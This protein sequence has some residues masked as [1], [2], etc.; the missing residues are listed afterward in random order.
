MTF[1]SDQSTCLVFGQTSTFKPYS[2][3][4][5]HQFTMHNY[6]TKK[7]PDGQDG[8]TGLGRFFL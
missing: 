4:L 3:K 2:I 1:I 8:F 5:V 7:I 6:V